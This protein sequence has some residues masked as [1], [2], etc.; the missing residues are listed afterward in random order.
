MEEKILLTKRQ[1]ES[2]EYLKKMY[3]N[4]EI[5]ETHVFSDG[6][7]WSH[8]AEKVNDLTTI[9]L[10]MAL[11]NG[12]EVIETVEEKIMERILQLQDEIS[13]ANQIM[14]ENGYSNKNIN[15][16]QNAE[17]KGLEFAY[18]LLMEQKKK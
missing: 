7:A 2:L 8:E 13:S 10:A 12:Y 3:S 18:D 15:K 11:I 17:I 16:E 14:L 5:L 6:E 4:E 9:E 1:S